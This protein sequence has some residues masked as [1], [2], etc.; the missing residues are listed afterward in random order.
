MNQ[1]TELKN[2]IHIFMHS[3]FS[4]K[5]IKQSFNILDAGSLILKNVDVC[6]FDFVWE[7]LLSNTRY[8][9]IQEH[10]SFV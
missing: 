10:S 8:I 3:F 1:R 5:Y 4:I 2:H 6:L 7:I 9:D